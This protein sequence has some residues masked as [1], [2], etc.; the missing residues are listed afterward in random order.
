MA[1]AGRDGAVAPEEPVGGSK[2]AATA[3]PARLPIPALIRRNTY[4]LTAAEAFI[5][6][7]QQMV[8]TLGA[9]M[10]LRL[11]GSPLFAGLGSSLLGLTRVL[12]SYPSG[13]FADSH[14]RKPILVLGLILSLFGAIGL[15]LSMLASSLPLFIAALLLFG[16]GN[17]A[18]QQQRRLSAADLY[19]PELR[20]RGL[21]TVLTG[22]VIGAF[23]GPVLIHAAGH[24]SKSLQIDQLALS[25]FLV[26]V[27]LVPSLALLTL[28][29]PDPREI[30]ASLG[31]F[32]PG[33]KRRASTVSSSQSKLHA[34][35]GPNTLLRTYPHLVAFVCMFVLF[36]N[37]SMMMAL[38]PITMTDAGLGLAAISLTV[39]IHVV[40]MYALSFPMGTLADRFGRKP[41]LLAGVGLSTLGTILVALTTAYSLIVLGLF[42]IGVGWCCGNVSTAAMVADAAPTEVRGRA[43]GTNSSF[44]AAASVSAPLLG[45]ILLNYLGPGSLVGITAVFMVPCVWLILRLKE[46]RPGHFSHPTL[47][48]VAEELETRRAGRRATARA[49]TA[50]ASFE[51]A[52][53]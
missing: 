35:I 1:V 18:S 7:G 2:G 31:D 15:G 14:G 51:E 17:G 10:I 26:P 3:L 49:T 24:W 13:R 39:S 52:G 53:P 27:V 44:S 20:A 12:V 46:T 47:M 19:P 23:G 4:L 25:W 29:R 28:I 36:G 30:A 11:V 37:M 38:A 5:G 41:L 43:M 40:G 48:E 32:Y 16:I 45:G 22:S 9:L 6:T 8:P 50:G 21:G 33:Y 42:A 34:S